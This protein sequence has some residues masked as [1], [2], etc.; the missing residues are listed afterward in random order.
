M[1]VSLE[2]VYWSSLLMNLNHRC[3]AVLIDKINKTTYHYLIVLEMNEE[4][5][6]QCREVEVDRLYQIS[7]NVKTVQSECILQYTFRRKVK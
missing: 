7:L 1:L 4:I 3:I 5:L 2:D 6:N